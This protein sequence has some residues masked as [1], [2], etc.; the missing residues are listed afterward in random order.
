[1]ANQGLVPANNQ[2]HKGC[3]NTRP[4]RNRLRALARAYVTEVAGPAP[5]TVDAK[6]RDLI[7]QRAGVAAFSTLVN[8]ELA[9]DPHLLERGEPV[10]SVL[11]FPAEPTTP[12]ALNQKPPV[13]PAPGS[14]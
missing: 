8:Q 10:R 12:S 1:M 5:A 13:P 9:E 14:A 2:Q 11:R 4:G 7:L 6:R 3:G